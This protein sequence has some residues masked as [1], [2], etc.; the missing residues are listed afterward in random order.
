VWMVIAAYYPADYSNW[1]DYAI[2]PIGRICL[3][4]WTI[5]F[6]YHLANGVRHLF[7]DMGKGYTIPVATRSG[8]MVVL[9]TL[10]MTAG[11]WAYIYTK[12]GIQ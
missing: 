7:W 8:I 4:G 10:A 6:F 12:A 5:S 9:F 3:L 11:S 1:Y 2:S